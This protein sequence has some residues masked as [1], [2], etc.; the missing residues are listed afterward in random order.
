MAWVIKISFWELSFWESFVKDLAV[1]DLIDGALTVGDIIDGALTVGDGALIVGDLI[2]GDLIFGGGTNTDL[3]LIGDLKVVPLIDVFVLTER[4]LIGVI[5]CKGKNLVLDG[6][7][8]ICIFN[9]N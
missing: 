2:V 3:A 4:G 7:L 9:K 6:E 8:W 1:G 5:F